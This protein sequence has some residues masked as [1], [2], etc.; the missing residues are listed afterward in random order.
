MAT[1]NIGNEAFNST[2]IAEQVQGDIGFLRSRIE[3]LERQP[4]PN[5]V[6]MQTYRD[7]LES[8]QAVLDWLVQDQKVS[9]NQLT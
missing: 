9:V 4:N 7:M 2:E 8:R 5:P 1:L 6:V 3:L